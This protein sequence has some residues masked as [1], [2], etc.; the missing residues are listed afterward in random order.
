MT[1]HTSSSSGPHTH[2][3]YVVDAENAAE[4]ARLM[5][6]DHM[7]TTALGGLIPELSDLSTIYQVLDIGCG[8][9]G[10]LLDLA[11]QCP[12]LQG[13]GIDISQLMI[14]YANTLA[15]S[16]GLSTLQFRVMDATGPLDFP[17]NTFDL[18]NARI[19]TGFLSREQWTEL[20]SECF[21]ITRPGGILRLTEVE[22]GF[23]NSTG[24]DALTGLA[25]LGNF[26]VGHSFSPSGRTISTTP[27][28]RLLQRRAGYQ[29]IESSAHAIDFSAGTPLHE[30]SVQNNLVFHKLIQPFLVQM[31]LS[32]QGELDTLHAQMEAEFE[33][34]EFCGIDYYLTV[35]GKKR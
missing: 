14:D 2:E 31:G 1:D 19:L 28:L 21:R 35:W 32:T 11:T 9:G 12:H 30:S 4:M 18:I 24:L 22:W 17:D 33:S 7:L 23:T 13:T 25:A 16:K 26:R 5:L 6:Q 10:W 27:V 8:P 20:L 34:E 15:T 3:G 29:E